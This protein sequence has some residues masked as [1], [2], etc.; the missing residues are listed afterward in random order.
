MNEKDRINRK[1]ETNEKGRTNRKS[2]KNK[3]GKRERLK[4]FEPTE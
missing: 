4:G 2:E 1:S 3:E